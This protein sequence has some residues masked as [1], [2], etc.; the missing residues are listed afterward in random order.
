MGCLE[1][2][3]ECLRFANLNDPKDANIWLALAEVE[4]GLGNFVMVNQCL[5]CYE[6]GKSE[7]ASEEQERKIG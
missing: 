7:N 2:A 5:N 6:Y 3:A 4:A 1:E